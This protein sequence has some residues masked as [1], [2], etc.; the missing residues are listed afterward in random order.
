MYFANVAYIREQLLMHI[1]DYSK[2]NDVRYVVMEMTPVISIDSTAIHALEGLLKDLRLRKITLAFATL[3]NR[4]EKA[5]A[6][7][8]L[9]LPPRCRAQATVARLS[10]TP[11]RPR[12]DNEEGCPLRGDWVGVVPPPC[13]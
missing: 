11:L 13:P 1:N 10:P 6:H 9:P 12:A 3:G 7:P 8:G 5:R 4:V 2:F